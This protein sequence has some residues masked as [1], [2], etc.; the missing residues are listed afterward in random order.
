[1]TVTLTAMPKFP[2]TPKGEGQQQRATKLVKHINK[3]QTQPPIQIKDP[4]LNDNDQPGNNFPGTFIPRDKYDDKFDLKQRISTSNPYNGERVNYA[5]KFTGKD[6]EYMKR[7]QEIQDR[8]RFEEYMSSALDM[9]DPKKGKK[10][11]I[12]VNKVRKR[13]RAP[14][15]V[16]VRKR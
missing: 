10:R 11:R 12:Q 14:T 4:K 3:R 8:L 7:K 2:D 16:R 9:S 13:R 5:T 6:M 15:I 1:M